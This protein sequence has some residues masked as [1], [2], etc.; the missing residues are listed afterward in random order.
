MGKVD[1]LIK[2]NV[3][4]NESLEF[5]GD[6]ESYEESLKDFKD[7]FKEKLENLEYYKNNKDCSN[8]AIIAH[9]IKSEAKYLGFM[10]DAEVFYEHEL[11]G[12]ANDIDFINNNFDDLKNTISKIE[13][14]LD[15]YFNSTETDVI[16]KNIIIADDSNIMINFMQDNINDDYNIL[17]AND[18]RD[19]IKH[20]KLND[21]YALF[22]DIN[23]PTKNGFEVLSYLKENELI[24]K[25]PVIIITG[26]DS[27]ETIKKAFTYPIL[28]VLNKPFTVDKIKRAL[29]SIENFYE[30]K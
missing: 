4:V 15:E 20:I 21:I 11:K 1:L 19:A 2:N 28:D 10:K 5:W 8:Y 3:L 12:K 17:R 22:L 13:K 30:Q 7:S 24:E 27:E 29:I 14:L 18:G 9:S 26:D 25:I 16:K 23:M 6:M